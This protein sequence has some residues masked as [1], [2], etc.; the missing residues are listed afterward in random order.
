MR[1]VCFNPWPTS[2]VT[3]ADITRFVNERKAKGFANAT[4]NREVE[5]LRRALRL[6]VE[7]K[8]IVRVPVF[9]QKLSGKNARQG[10]FETGDFLK[11]LRHLPEPLDDMARFAFVTGWRRGMLL[12]MKWSHV[13]RAGRVVSLPDS[14]NGDPQSVPL[15]DELL[16]LIER[17]WETR[18]YRSR[19]GTSGL[20]EY[21]FHRHGRPISRPT[22]N[23]EFA[24]ARDAAGIPGKLFHDLRRTAARNMI[25]GGVPQSVAMR[26]T[27][28]RSDSMFRRYDVASV[29]DKLEAI[30]KARAYAATRTAVGE[31]VTPFPT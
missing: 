19:N 7:T 11:I 6:G 28:H 16:A 3:T 25:R 27:G 29:D 5:L 17:R 24:R 1:P 14:K 21:V 26:V 12:G 13:D 4:V 23:R 30:Q 15:D 31:N 20:S 18:E 8:R 2:G 9:P 10:F 22:F